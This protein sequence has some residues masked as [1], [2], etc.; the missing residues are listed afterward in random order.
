MKKQSISVLM[1][2]ICLLQACNDEKTE[3]TTTSKDS[4][5]VV[6]SDTTA[7]A[8]TTTMGQMTTTD[9]MYDM[10]TK[11]FVMKAADGGM[12]EVELGKIAQQKAQS[13]RV[14]N[15]ADMIVADHTKAN[16]ELKSIVTT[17]I[18]MPAAMSDEHQK[19]IELLKN[20]SGADFDKSYINMMIDDHKK[21]IAEFKKAS[22]NVK[23]AGIKGFATNA[24]PVL[25]KHLDSAKAIHKSN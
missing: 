9:Q 2:S 16:D 21:D 6:T 5:G 7:K 4:T 19:N 3:N 1:I 12:M 17:K 10:D 23:D 20:K 14:K 18:V 13:Q 11:D 8:D 15:Y 25:Q 22:Q 24:L